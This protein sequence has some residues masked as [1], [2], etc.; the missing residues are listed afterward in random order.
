MDKR[1]VE[2]VEK[3]LIKLDNLE[4][5]ENNMVLQDNYVNENSTESKVM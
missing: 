5:K 1:V 2:I 3:I 4:M